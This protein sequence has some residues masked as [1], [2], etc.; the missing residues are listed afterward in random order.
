M[1]SAL[2]CADHPKE[3]KG[4]GHAGLFF[5]KFFDGF[6]AQFTDFADKE[7]AKRDFLVKFKGGQGDGDALSQACLR[8]INLV[9]T[10]GGQ[11]FVVSTTRNSPFVTGLGNLH[12]VEN[13]FL[14]HYTLGTPYMQ[15]SAIKGILRSWLEINLGYGAVDSD[16]PQQDFVDLKRY[17]G[18]ETKS[19]Q[20]N[21]VG[22][23]VFFDAL[24]I[25]RPMLKTEVMTPH[26]GKYYAQGEKNPGQADTIPADWH[27]PTP[28]PFLVVD[29]ASFLVSFAPRM[30]LP[31]E[32]KQAIAAELSNLVTALKNAL[33]HIGAGA[34]TATG[35]G[36]LS[37]N[38][39]ASNDLHTHWQAQK[40][41]QARGQMSPQMRLI[42][43]LSNL[44][45]SS[46]VN[47]LMPGQANYLKLL[48]CIKQT[49]DWSKE[50][51]DQLWQNA[52]NSWLEKT[53]N[54]KKKQKENKKKFIDK[55][56]WLKTD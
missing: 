53:F 24:P 3:L 18:S 55:H 38:E 31:A 2:Y 29:T 11:W 52:L 13:G 14:W 21:Q 41:Q 56:P 15:G 42:K 54:D 9:E 10:L 51:I 45:E 23:L 7:N 49:Q 22:Q 17:F 34:K 27:S 8:Q 46:L 12:P 33:A 48:E 19:S 50:H 43:D 25:E 40:I 36:R 47:T 4:N 44:I 39:K 16:N 20:N 35:F 30:T 37:E 1:S 26:M 28:I 5:Q 32:Q 6:N